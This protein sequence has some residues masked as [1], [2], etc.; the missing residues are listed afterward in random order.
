MNRSFEEFR[1]Q[2]LLKHLKTVIRT[3]VGQVV[4][5]RDPTSPAGK[6][7]KLTDSQR[8]NYN[9][10]KGMVFILQTSGLMPF[11]FLQPKEQVE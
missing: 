7:F 8:T 11:N 6:H 10:S 3:S 5:S 1:S 9:A 4:F 2:S